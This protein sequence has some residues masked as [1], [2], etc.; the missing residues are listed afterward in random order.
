M[1]YDRNALSSRLWRAARFGEVEALETLLGEGASALTP[2]ALSGAFAA[3]VE[4][5]HVSA[6]E[7][8]GRTMQ[9]DPVEYGKALNA[10]AKQAAQWGHLEILKDLVAQGADPT[11]RWDGETLLHQ[12]TWARGDGDTLRW[13][14]QFVTVDEPDRHGA[15]ALMHA[16]QN[17]FLEPVKVLRALGADP[18]RK[19]AR[20]RNVFDY[21]KQGLA[22][23]VFEPEWEVDRS[24][25]HH[26]NRPNDDMSA[27]ELY[28][29]ICEA[30][31]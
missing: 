16:A 15:T 11:I 1:S 28:L 23:S 7:I 9:P 24:S 2:D 26:F 18:L 14:A 31:A 10:G 8:L 29:R 19:N 13:I 21:A 22:I 20:G 4:G 6:V 27:A 17:L 12:A 3:A 25:P 5:A 30:L